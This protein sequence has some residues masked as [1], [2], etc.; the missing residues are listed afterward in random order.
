MPN[1]AA[2]RCFNHAQREAAARCPQCGRFFCRECL[3]EHDDRVICA[4]CLKN[5]ARPPLLER[6]G[7]TAVLR[8]AQCLASVLALW[9]FFYVLG[10]RLSQLP[11]TFH[12]SSLWHATWWNTE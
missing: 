11:S 3:T 9:L 12:E 1:L 2:Q 6:R 5:L 7:V 8:T 10:D 4:A